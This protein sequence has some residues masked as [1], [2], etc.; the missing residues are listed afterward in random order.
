MCRLRF[1]GWFE[2]L[3][4][5]LGWGEIGGGVGVEFGGG[6]EVGADRVLVDVSAAG[7]EVIAVED[8]MVGVAT[9]PDG[10]LR[11]EAT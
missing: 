8:E 11:G 1:L 3:D 2:P 10:K 7:F 4:R 5:G 9:L 6:D